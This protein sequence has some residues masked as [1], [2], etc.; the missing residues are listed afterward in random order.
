LIE[1]A[2]DLKAQMTRLGGVYR[3]PDVLPAA[4]MVAGVALLG[5]ALA[6]V[7]RRAG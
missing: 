1:A 6:R 7:R 3:V 4:I 2:P 5:F